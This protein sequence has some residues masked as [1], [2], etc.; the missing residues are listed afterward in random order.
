MRLTYLSTFALLL[1]TSVHAQTLL[2]TDTDLKTAYCITV[3]KKSIEGLSRAPIAQGTPGYDYMQ[4][5]IRDRNNDLH[6]LQSYLLPKLP[7]LDA[8]GLLAAAR[9]AEADFPAS[10]EAAGQ[11]ATHCDSTLESGSMGNKWLACMNTCTA[12]SAV[13]V[14]VNSCRTINWLPF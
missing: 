7:S 9:R 12:E 1:S 10:S 4:G 6:R 14:R 13:Y 2:P 11:C 5:M 8:T 3:A